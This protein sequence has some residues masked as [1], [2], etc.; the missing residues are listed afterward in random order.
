MIIT[1]V[2][3]L[4]LLK[5]EVSSGR[6]SADSLSAAFATFRDW[7]AGTVISGLV[8]QS[9][10]IFKLLNNRC[11]TVQEVSNSPFKVLLDFI[12]LLTLFMI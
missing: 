9:T 6:G 11:K 10:D 1:S 8:F 3:N 4:A 5:C 12:T 7:M 2:C